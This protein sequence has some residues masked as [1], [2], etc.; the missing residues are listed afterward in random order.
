MAAPLELFCSHAF[1]RF[2][3]QYLRVG[4]SVWSHVGAGVAM[5][6]M[7]W[8]WVGWMGWDEME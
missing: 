1:A 8:G 3:L 4:A 6:D 5:G 2:F 7:G